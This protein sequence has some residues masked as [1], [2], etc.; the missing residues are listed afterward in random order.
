MCKNQSAFDIEL[1]MQQP[2]VQMNSMSF[3][4]NLLKSFVFSLVMLLS[5]HVTIC[6]CSRDESESDEDSGE[7]S[8]E[9]LAP[10]KSAR[11]ARARESTKPGDDSEDSSEEESE[12]EDAN[13]RRTT[14]VYTSKDKHASI[15]IDF[16]IVGV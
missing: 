4:L 5:M 3:G 2:W 9:E 13:L 11:R 1:R 14:R 16:P 10:P 12:E 8:G 6:R 7:E 15:Q